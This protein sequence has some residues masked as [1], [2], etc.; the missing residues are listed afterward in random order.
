MFFL[1]ALAAMVTA[2]AIDRHRREQQRRAW[3]AEDARRHASHA[4]PAAWP[5]PRAAGDDAVASDLAAQQR[6]T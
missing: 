5:D 6:S 3:L 4:A 2:D 1:K